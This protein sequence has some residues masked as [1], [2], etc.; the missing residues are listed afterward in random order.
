MTRAL[1]L[2]EDGWRDRRFAQLVALYHRCGCH[3]D[4]ILRQTDQ[5]QAMPQGID[6]L[7]V[8]PPGVDAGALI[9]R[10]HRDMPVNLVH[11]DRD[12]AM[13]RTRPG[14]GVPVIA[15]IDTDAGAWQADWVPTVTLSSSETIRQTLSLSGHNAV[16][17]PKVF[18]PKAP[19]RL[20]AARRIGW[21]GRW[22]ED[23]MARWCTLAH[24]FAE[25]SI[26]PDM[27]FLLLGPGFLPTRMPRGL[28]VARREGADLS[29]LN[30]LDIAVA[31]I[32]S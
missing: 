28:A 1:I 3:V 10:M 23:L 8:L 18:H 21:Y 15:D 6:R 14:I 22:T 5:V 7:G 31:P 9:E 11:L 12:P 13:A 19:W 16:R 20:P 4:A 24:R 27:T 17:L 25:Q 2:S 32:D 26:C 29:A 30:A